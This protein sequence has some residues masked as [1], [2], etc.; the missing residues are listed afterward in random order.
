MNSIA[1]ELTLPRKTYLVLQQAAARE[2]KT[3]AEFV[4]AV[5]ETYLSSSTPVD[6]L[7][8]LFADE[9]LLID[10]VTESVMLD[11]EQMKLRTGEA[12]GG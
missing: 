1:I 6:P 11:R 7:L 3:E 8:G 12:N 9:Q 4:Q 10:Q 2:Q 5:L